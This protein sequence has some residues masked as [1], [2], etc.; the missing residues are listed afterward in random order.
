MKE[1][2]GALKKKNNRY[3]CATH[4]HDRSKCLNECYST[5][6]NRTLRWSAV[7]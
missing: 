4:T 6:A 3:V 2:V 5:L 1:Y 7:N